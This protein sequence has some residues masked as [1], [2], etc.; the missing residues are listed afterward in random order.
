MV[1]KGELVAIILGLHLSHY[2]IGTCDHINL[3]IDNQVTIKMMDN[4]HPQ[5]AQYLI[6]TIK[7]DINRIHDKEK[8][9]RIRQNMA[10]WLEMEITLTWITGH[11]DSKG[12][13][14]V[15]K[16]AKIAAEFRLSSNDLLPPFL[17]RNLLESLLAIKQQID[18]E[19]KKETMAWWKRSKWYKRIK[20]I[21]SLLPSSK[22]AQA[23][24]GL[25]HRQTSA[26]T[27]LCTGHI[28]LN[29]HLFQINKVESPHCNHCP[30]AIENVTHFLFNCN[31]YTLQRHRLIMAVKQKAFNVKHIL[32]NPSTMCHTLNFI[33]NTSRL[34]HIYGDISTE[35]MDVNTH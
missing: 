34:R 31:K 13:K 4:N 17:H 6:D 18:N 33:N 30:G 5:S 23:T 1:F 11:M 14:V 26:L 27:Q 20:A 19:M 9:K 10:N 12:N 32:S 7:H 21:D 25:N 16:Q 3:N 28:P 8:A 24:V 22:Y 2:A 35:L 29:S 15:D